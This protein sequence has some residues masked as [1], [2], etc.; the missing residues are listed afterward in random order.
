MPHEHKMTRR[1]SSRV[2]LT[3][4]QH[5][6]KKEEGAEEPKTKSSGLLRARRERG[7]AYSSLHPRAWQHRGLTN[8]HASEWGKAKERRKGRQVLGR[9][10]ELEE[11]PGLLAHSSLNALSIYELVIYKYFLERCSESWLIRGEISIIC[12]G[13]K[14]QK[15]IPFISFVS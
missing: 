9:V 5:G 12:K 2:A 13:D 15:H 4:S 7:L 8:D 3:S 10:A 14:I 6:Q 11:N 1:L